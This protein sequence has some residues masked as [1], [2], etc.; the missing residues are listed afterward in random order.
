[1]LCVPLPAVG[2]GRMSFHILVFFSFCFVANKNALVSTLTPKQGRCSRGATLFPDFVI[3]SD[4]LWKC[5]HIPRD[6]TV[7]TRRRILMFPCAL[8]GPFERSFPAG[9][10]PAPLL[11]KRSYSSVISASQLMAELYMMFSRS[12]IP[13]GKLFSSSFPRDACLICRI[14][15]MRY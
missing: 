1:M 5:Q 6:I 11:S 15:E 7:T 9:L 8:C 3:K 14:D 12:S 13:F 10:S 4:S 2:R